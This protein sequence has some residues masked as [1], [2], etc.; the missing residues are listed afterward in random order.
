M[1][2][3][4]DSPQALRRTA[5]AI[6][7]FRQVPLG[8]WVEENQFIASVDVG[9]YH[10]PSGVNVVGHIR[11][12]TMGGEPKKAGDK[13]RVLVGGNLDRMTMPLCRYAHEVAEGLARFPRDSASEHEA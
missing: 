11:P 5:L 2:G 13:L 3:P 8:R 10:D 4:G 12:T 1:P 6:E 7:R 9:D